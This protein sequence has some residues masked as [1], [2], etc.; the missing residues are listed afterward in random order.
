MK[1]S[2]EK[3]TTINIKDSQQ[4]VSMWDNSVPEVENRT[5]GTGSKNAKIKL[6]KTP[7]K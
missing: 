1:L 5:N 6:K 7:V 2:R 3:M 4:S